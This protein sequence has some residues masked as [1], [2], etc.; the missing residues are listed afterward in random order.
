M[1]TVSI[2]RQFSFSIKRLLL[3]LATTINAAALFAQT[4]LKVGTT[5][6]SISPSAVFE[7][8]AT[9][10]GMLIPRVTTAQM[11]AISA[12]SLGLMVFNTNLNCLHFYFSGWKS[13]CDPA[14]LGAWSLL[15]NSG[16]VDGTNF[17]GTTDNIPLSIRVN[18][19]KAGRVDHLLNNAFWGYQAGNAI[20]SGT[21][22][23]A[24]GTT[25]LSTMTT[26]THN[27]AIGGQSA[28]SNTTGIRNVTL[29]YHSGRNGTFSNSILIGYQAGLQNA[30]SNNVFMGSLSGSLTNTGADNIALG[31]LSLFSNISGANNVAI[32]SSALTTVNGWGN[33]AVGFRSG[34]S[35]Q[36]ANAN[37]AVGDSALLNNVLG[38]NNTM[39]GYRSGEWATG[40][41]NIAIGYNAQLPVSTASNQL[42][43]GSWLYGTGGFLGIN[44]INPQ[45]KL[46]ID[47]QTGSS[48]NPLRLLGLNAGATSDSII[49][50]NS[51]ILRRLSI[52]QVLGNA[53]NIAGNSGTVAGTNFLGTIDNIPLSIRI[54]NQKAGRISSTGETYL[55]YL[56]GNAITTGTYNTFIGDNAGTATT[57]GSQNVGVGS[58]ALIDNIGGSNNTAVGESALERNTSGNNNVG[59]GRSALHDNSTGGNNTAIGLE[60]LDLSM[61][62]GNTAVGYQAGSLITSGSNNITIGLGAQV[63]TATA[64]NQLSIG[65][66]IYGVSGNIGIGTA[67]PLS[68]ARLQ[69]ENTGSNYALYAPTNTNR[70]YFAGNT[71]FGGYSSNPN[72]ISLLWGSTAVDNVIGL[73]KDFTSF[74]AGTLYRGLS[75]VLRLSPSSNISNLIHGL[76]N[77]IQTNAS[78]TG[79]FTSLIRAVGGDFRHYG[80]GTVSEVEGLNAHVG[81]YGSGT[82]TDAYGVQ[83]HVF[84]STGTITNAYGGQFLAWGGSTANY[85]LYSNPANSATNNYMYYGTMVGSTNTDWGIYLTGEDKNYFS[86]NVGIGCTAPQYKLHVVG[87]IA[88]SGILRASS[89]T[90]ST[91]ITACS[92]FRFKTNITPLSNALQNVMKLQGVTYDWLKKEFPDRY[93]N[94]RKQIGIIAQE[95]EKVYPE[96]VN[97]DEKGYKSVDYSKMTPI[98]VEAIKTQ[99]VL[100]ETQKKDIDDLKNQAHITQ[101]NIDTLKKQL[102][103]FSLQLEALAKKND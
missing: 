83:A 57:N 65:N 44:T 51:G 38:S 100:I 52:A 48:G 72:D 31:Y 27:V 41:N 8:A 42:A 26:G 81:N 75:T 64:S 102:A 37:V 28:L 58:T 76:T 3:L 36:I 88:A 79:N 19:Q 46:D 90:V 14:N 82:I 56:S 34:M 39:L 45:Y 63:P 95:L 89:A 35:M 24:M 16:T 13:Q 20:T 21:D 78:S 80:S 49:S 32:G 54:N 66:W 85:G 40:S 94:D 67:S 68:T 70:N 15:G 99:Q 60:S 17:I 9:T 69:V 6:G 98:L 96:L 5:P 91:T 61:A 22:N 74:T 12:P 71:A 101:Q 43:L 33:T 23:V 25:A 97:T 2:N 11:N 73:Q 93:F 84:K 10:K 92:D 4:D 47:A 103:Q 53:W 55:G 86:G 62:S 1:F 50:S 29:G 7:A 30:A 59:V 87:D 77:D 18:N